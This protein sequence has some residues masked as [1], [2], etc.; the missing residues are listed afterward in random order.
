MNLTNYIKRL[1]PVTE[2]SDLQNAVANTI[3]ELDSKTIPLLTTAAAAY[4]TI[5]LKSPEAINLTNK[6]RFAFKLNKNEAI[7]A[8]MLTALNEASK[9]INFVAEK[10]E[11]LA[12]ETISSLN[13]DARVATCMQLVETCSWVARYARKFVEYITI[14]E[15]DSSGLYSNYKNEQITK[16]EIKF[17]EERYSFFL[18]SLE[19]ISEKDFKFKKKFDE[20]PAVTM[21]NDNKA[22]TLF[23]KAKMDPFRLGFIPVKYNPF[24]IIGKWIA[25]YEVDR[26]KEAQED[27]I[28]TKNRIYLLEQAQ[29][30]NTDPRVEKEIELLRIKAE[31]LTYRI[32][33]TEESIQ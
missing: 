32:N 27:L 14:L 31:K 16:G 9:N 6:Y 25:E 7:F 11:Q 2:K 22:D 17:I 28:R 20:I 12:P 23:S 15:T 33:K 3:S 10:I 4:K 24:F 8:H 13:I 21:S 5:E 26:Y 29:K 19:F 1:K 30:G 18:S